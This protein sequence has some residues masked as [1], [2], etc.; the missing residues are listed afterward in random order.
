V[1]KY[2]FKY[3]KRAT[4]KGV[5]PVALKGVSG[6]KEITPVTPSVTFY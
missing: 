2:Y 3:I 1:L 6:R 4:G 5:K